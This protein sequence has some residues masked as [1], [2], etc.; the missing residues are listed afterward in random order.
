MDAGTMK[1][2]V[3]G[4]LAWLGTHADYPPADQA[5]AIALVSHSFIEDLACGSPC[6]VLGVYPDGNIVYVD[7]ALTPETNICARSVILHELVH[8]LQDRNQRFLN[9]PPVIRWHVREIEAYGL[10]RTY[11]LENGIEVA[12]APKLYLGAVMGPAC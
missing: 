6:D 12:K 2:I 8:Y 9:L 10:Q 3:A 5:P 1:A 4:L 11:L 7:A